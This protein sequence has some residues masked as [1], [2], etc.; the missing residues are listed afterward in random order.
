MLAKWNGK[1]STTMYTTGNK[2]PGAEIGSPSSST[3]IDVVTNNNKNNNTRR[4]R[5][6][7]KTR[8]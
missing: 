2:Y 6:P 3:V 8:K 1:K 7:S 4:S 5:S